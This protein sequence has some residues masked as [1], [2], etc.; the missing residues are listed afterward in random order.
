LCENQC[1]G[2]PFRPIP[3]RLTLADELYQRALQYLAGRERLPDSAGLVYLG[4]GELCR[5]R[6][7]LDTATH[8]L[9]QG[10]ELVWH[11]PDQNARVQ[12]MISL[13]WV[14]QARGDETGACAALT[15][16]ECLG[17]A[18]ASAAT[19]LQLRAQR[20]RLAL[21]QGEL[22]L[23][24]RWGAE[25]HVGEA[26]PAEDLRSQYLYRF[27]QSTRARLLIAQGR[28]GEA[29]VLIERL[30]LLAARA[31]WG[32]IT[33]SLAAV[34]A[35][36]QRAQGN[37]AAALRTL[38][39]TLAQAEPEGYVRL[40]ADEGLGMTHLLAEGLR[41]G[42]WPEPRLARYAGRLLAACTAPSA[43]V[44]GAA[45]QPA[46]VPVL[47]GDRPQPANSTAAPE[48][49]SEREKDVLRLLD[50]GL[51]NRQIAERL[52]LSLG[53]VKT[54]IHNIYAKLGV[55]DR[56]HALMRAHGLRLL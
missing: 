47:A 32:R 53:T 41:R 55:Q 49:L 34:T 12:G 31:G 42:A 17:P 18:K 22:A 37:G 27:V 40:F 39:G 8:Y 36:A 16:A 20:A 3:C 13:A 48:P 38:S 4:F 50:E 45:G 11:R 46:P 33:I 51:S 24:E 30:R 15:E 52:F 14:R 56:Q 9:N 44:V 5:A 43:P 19:L 10:L 26:P 7:N 21:L 25:S 29:L 23:A 2:L 35:L 28:A 1:A 54:H 6:G